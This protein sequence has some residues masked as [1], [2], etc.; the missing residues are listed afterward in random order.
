MERRN[1]QTQKEVGVRQAGEWVSGWTGRS[2][3]LR[4]KAAAVNLLV[5]HVIDSPV[6][7]A[8]LACSSTVC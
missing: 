2:Q 8:G 6:L 5:S 7:I 3:S 4:S 1:G